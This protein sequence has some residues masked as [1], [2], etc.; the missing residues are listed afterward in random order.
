M[1]AVVLGDLIYV[2]N[3]GRTFSTFPFVCMLFILLG[4]ETCWQER[5][6]LLYRS[7]RMLTRLQMSV[8][9]VVR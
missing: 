3:L 2:L 7:A 1:L 4:S 6:V 9:A 5:F 8:I